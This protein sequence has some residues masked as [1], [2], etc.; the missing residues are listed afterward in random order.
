MSIVHFLQ[1]P[2]QSSQLLYLLKYKRLQVVPTVLPT[3]PQRQTA[4]NSAQQRQTAPNSTKQ[5]QTATNSAK[6][7]QA[8]ATAAT[9]ASTDSAD[10]QQHREQSDIDSLQCLRFITAT[11]TPNTGATAPFAYFNVDRQRSAALALNIVRCF[12]ERLRQRSC[13]S[14]TLFTSYSDPE[15]IA[16]LLW[17]LAFSIYIVCGLLGTSQPPLVSLCIKQGDKH[18]KHVQLVLLQAT[19]QTLL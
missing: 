16:L 9:T 6:L 10:L 11:A 7:H 17:S 1:T 19:L 15:T 13:D 2:T 14:D 8:S 4:P 18:L 5:Q 12:N 3:T